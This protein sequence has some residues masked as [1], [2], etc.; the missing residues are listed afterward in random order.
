M[1]SRLKLGVRWLLTVAGDFRALGGL[2]VFSCEVGISM[3]N[4]SR[5]GRGNPL[6]LL[7]AGA[8]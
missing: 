8:E 1:L 3:L 7:T 4:V 2:E 6:P 5:D